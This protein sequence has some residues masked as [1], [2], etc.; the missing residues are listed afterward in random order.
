MRWR[1]ARLM[2]IGVALV[3]VAVVLT[4]YNILDDN[5]AA[6]ASGEMWCEIESQLAAAEESATQLDMP[7]HV[8]YPEMEMPVVEID[9]ISYVGTLEIPMCNLALPV[10]DE[11]S[12]PNLKIAP[13]RYSG[14]AYKNNLILAG[15]NYKSQ[16][17]Q[18]KKLSVG[19]EIIFIDMA[20]NAFLYQVMAQEVLEPTEVMEMKTGDWDL[21]LFTCTYGGQ[22]RI[23]VRCML[24]VK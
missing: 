17:G 13:C 1:G 8:L 12:D 24:V 19:D 23:A 14:S 20:G 11:L 5:R 3:A 2:G 9:G 22:K 4:G 21:T 16:F 10:I 15:H 18:L 6:Q 7:E